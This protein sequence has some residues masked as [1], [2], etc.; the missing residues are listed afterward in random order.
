MNLNERL[1][2]VQDCLNA[3]KYSWVMRPPLE[4]EALEFFQEQWQVVLPLEYSQFLQTIG[5]GGPGPYYGVFSLEAS[6]LKNPGQHL[7]KEKNSDHHSVIDHG[8]PSADFP[9]NADSVTDVSVLETIGISFGNVPGSIAISNYGCGGVVR[10]VVTGSRKGSVWLDLMGDDQ[11]LHL[12]E[13]SFLDWY[14]KW[15]SGGLP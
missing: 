2:A 8:L 9:L 7:P 6:V 12:Q 13:H 11:G 5:N 3:T 14:E 4:Q 15:L 1:R 10:L